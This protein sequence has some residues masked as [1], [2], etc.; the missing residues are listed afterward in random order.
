MVVVINPKARASNRHKALLV[1]GRN[2]GLRPA[3]EAACE[4]WES[5]CSGLPV[6]SSELQFRPGRVTAGKYQFAVS[7]TGSTSLVLQTVLMPLFLAGGPSRLV[8]EGG[9]HNMLAPP[10]D[11][12]ERTF[13][14]IINRMRP[15]VTAR[16]VRRSF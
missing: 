16:I 15:S 1:V 7:T 9:T 13:L 14:P 5:E 12:I 8:L 3:V 4:I 10:F 2:F 6:G 11:F